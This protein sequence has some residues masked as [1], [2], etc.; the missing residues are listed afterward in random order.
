MSVGTKICDPEV[1]GFGVLQYKEH[2]C[3]CATN[4]LN[5][6]RVLPQSR[7]YT[8]VKWYI[9]ALLVHIYKLQAL[10]SQCPN[11][12]QP[13]KSQA[14][15]AH[16]KRTKNRSSLGSWVH[17]DHYFPDRSASHETVIG[18]VRFSKVI[19]RIHNWT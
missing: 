12:I 10:S 18:C 2:L 14:T 13:T 8:C 5:V 3:L 15:S 4:K 7:Y 11:A 16:K 1:N 19:Y 17:L 9:S 6:K